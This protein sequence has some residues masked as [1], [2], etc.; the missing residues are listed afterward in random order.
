MDYI[1]FS[2]GT[3][4]DNQP[5]IRIAAELTKRGQKVLFLGNEKFGPLVESLGIEFKAVSSE[6]EY[7]KAYD[8]PTTWSH[9][10]AKEHY[11]EYHLPAIQPTYKIIE[12]VVKCGKR[13]FLLFQDP[14]SGARMACEDFNLPYSLIALAPSALFSVENPSFPL[15]E[16]VA[17]KDWAKGMAVVREKATSSKFNKLFTPFINP[18]RQELGLKPLGINELPS[19]ENAQSIIALFPEWLKEVPSDWPKQA[20][21]AGFPLEVKNLPALEQNILDFIH[22]KGSPIVYSFG[23]G[24]PLNQAMLNKIKK[25]SEILSL[26]SI[27][28]G[29]SIIDCTAYDLG[30]DILSVPYVE[31][32]AIFPKAKVIV[33]HGG[34]GTCA[35]GLAAGVP[36]LITPFAFD[37]P[38]NAFLLWKLGVGNAVNFLRTGA[39]EFADTIQKLSESSEVRKKCL[40]YKA[41]CRGNSIL[42][43]VEKI[44][45][46]NSDLRS[47]AEFHS[48]FLLTT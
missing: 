43:A 11:R 41:L 5:F 22:T 21:I 3:M 23:T 37:Q 1:I 25:V 32:S 18:I 27:L 33:H 7:I 9:Y 38:D 16:Q 6:Q 47:K 42:T 45:E 44:L 12:E 30:D 34:V 28:I 24:V 19:T 10:H 13:P 35:E 2:L 17:E 39:R 31:F 4:G 8:N 14:I 26:P 48:K 20:F 36:Q 40:N 46:I 29:K 15:R